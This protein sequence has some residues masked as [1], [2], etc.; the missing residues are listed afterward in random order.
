[1]AQRMHCG[2]KA[3]AAWQR[4]SDNVREWQCC[5]VAVTMVVTGLQC[6]SGS[7]SGSAAVAG[8]WELEMSAE[9]VYCMS[10]GKKQRQWQRGSVTMVVTVWQW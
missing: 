7:G 2:K 3:A 4:G 6:G 5:R 9:M 8:W 1:M 10:C